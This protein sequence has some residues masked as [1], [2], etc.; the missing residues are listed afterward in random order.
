MQFH[1]PGAS[2]QGLSLTEV[3]IAIFVMAI[4]MISL[5]VLFPVGMSNTRWAIQNNRAAVAANNANAMS[6]LSLYDNASG[7]TFSLRT[8]PAYRNS[9]QWATDDS[10]QPVFWNLLATTVDSLGNL[11]DPLNILQPN[12]WTY[13]TAGPAPVVY[14]DP[15]GATQWPSTVATPPYAP[16]LLGLGMGHS[17]T[18]AGPINFNLRRT[19]LLPLGGVLGNAQS[20][21]VPRVR[22]TAMPNALAAR[23]GCVL[24][25]D[26][27]FEE[28][29]RAVR[30][31]EPNRPAIPFVQREKRYSWAYMCRWPQANDPSIVDMSIV[32]YGG[33]PMTNTATF[34]PPNEVRYFGVPGTFAGLPR[35]RR[36]FLRGSNEAVIISAAPTGAPIRRGDWVLDNTLIMPQQTTS[37][38]GTVRYC[39]PFTNELRV[40]RMRELLPAIK[41]P[42]FDIALPGNILGFNLDTP[43]R[44]GISNGHFYQATSVSQVQAIPGVGY[45][46]TIILN[47]PALADGYEMVHMPNVV[48]VIEKNVGT[49]PVR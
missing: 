3:L 7:K 42:L 34:S 44:T 29:G 41:L 6:N 49:M 19:P 18:G 45:V 2:R 26:I 32:V 15:I 27:A 40:V 30:T 4:G 21:G 12:H 13:D 17:P 16:S 33:R 31:A 9:L 39:A 22:S 38:L 20:H 25:D 11:L 5:L 35:N 1:P 36:I 43:L 24:P 48:E 28:F 37:L 23:N 46:Q 47:R 8:D 10:G 14:V